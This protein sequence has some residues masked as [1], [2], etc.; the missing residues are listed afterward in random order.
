MPLV[1]MTWLVREWVICTHHRPPNLLGKE[2]GCVSE[3]STKLDLPPL[4]LLSLLDLVTP[5]YAPQQMTIPYLLFPFQTSFSS[6]RCE[7]FQ[8][9]F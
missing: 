9:G 3:I 1:D 6:L 4:C 8:L 7:A 2:K 5:I